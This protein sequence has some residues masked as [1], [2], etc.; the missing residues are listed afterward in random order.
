MRQ[1]TLLKWFRSPSAKSGGPRPFVDLY[2]GIGGASQG[3]VSAG[4]VV[5]LA[6]DADA[7]VLRTHAAN[8]PHTRHICCTL[9]PTQPLPLPG[10]HEDWHLH[11]S[12]PCTKLSQAFHGNHASARLADGLAHVRWSLDFALA[13]TAR[14]W[15]LEQVAT[16]P[17]LRLLQ[18]YRV[19]HRRTMAFHVFDFA[20][21]GVPQKRKRVLAG[22]P[23]LI[24]RLARK[25]TWRRS[26]RDVIPAARG[27]HTRNESVYASKPNRYGRRKW[28]G[29]DSF[30]LPITGPAHTVIT[31]KPPRWAT[32]H[33]DTPLV[34]F[35]MEETAALQ[36]FP[37]GYV[38]GPPPA[39]TGL[40]NALPPIIMQQLL[41]A[42]PQRRDAC[43]FQAC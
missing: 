24:S 38:L 19:R 17:V 8:H 9:P 43:P 2:C 40:G 32:P 41:E 37:E 42:D 22:T 10:R 18:A 15:S 34:R 33:T 1:P 29:P 28:N 35:S 30:C 16:A 20:C 3:A 13:S 6:V 11:L 27:T 31:I 25:R 23:A 12:P 4:C 39:I 7:H 5:A 14:T 26:V 36:T 21:L